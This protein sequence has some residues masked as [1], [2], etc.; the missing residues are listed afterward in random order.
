MVPVSVTDT[1]GNSVNDL[2]SS[3]FRIQENGEPEAIA[4]MFDPG[5]TPLDM[6]VLFD[7][8]GSVNPRF[9]FER[10]AAVAFLKK[11]LR[12]IDSVLILSVGPDP[13]L[14]Q[15]RTNSLQYALLAVETLEPTK[16]MTAFFDAVVMG[17]HLLGK[18]ASPETRR[19]EIV[20][21]DGED[22]N[23][24]NQ[25]G[26][27]LRDVLRADVIFYAINPSGPSVHLNQISMKGQEVLRSLAGQTGGAA[28]LPDSPQQ[29]ERIFNQIANELQA[30][31]L[32][33]YY[34]SNTS[35]DGS[36]RRI[37]VSVPTRPDLRIRARQGYYAPR[38]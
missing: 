20:I 24:T 25:I 26:D 38:N 14:L 7:I 12:P 29:F 18:S 3:D 22:N 35:T 17:A 6:A 10:E 16:E 31:Y 11:I 36:F 8:S 2:D 30:Q 13:K 15:P 1:K 4:K 27:A 34:P 37:I 5:A 19:V 28:F 33:G 23:S 9:Q 32:L 21:S